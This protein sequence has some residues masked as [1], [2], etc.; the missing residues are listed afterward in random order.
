M[1]KEKRCETCEWYRIGRGTYGT[2]RCVSERSYRKNKKMIL[3]NDTC[4]FWER[5]TN[6]R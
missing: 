6:D 5:S 3:K 2:G 4:K 1:T